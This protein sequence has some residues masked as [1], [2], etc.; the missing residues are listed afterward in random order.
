LSFLF[1]RSPESYYNSLENQ[2]GE[3][4]INVNLISSQLNSLSAEVTSIRSEVLTV[5]SE[6]G[7]FRTEMTT[8]RS[9][10]IG[11]SSKITN[12][13]DHLDRMED[14]NSKVS[15]NIHQVW[16]FKMNSMIVHLYSNWNHFFWSEMLNV[17][18][19]QVVYH[20]VS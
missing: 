16:V 14:S 19:I 11:F 1:Q 9:E 4:I 20:S 6:V 10:I 15:N 8:A 3:I 12:V 13:E 2:L 7:S 17:I 18:S 5:R